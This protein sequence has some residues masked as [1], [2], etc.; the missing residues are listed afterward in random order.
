MPKQSGFRRLAADRASALPP[1][2]SL[3]HSSI[4]IGPAPAC[5]RR[6][7]DTH[8]CAGPSRTSR[9]R[10]IPTCRRRTIPAVGAR[11]R[12]IIRPTTLAKPESGQAPSSPG[13]PIRGFVDWACRNVRAWT[14]PALP[15][16]RAG[17]DAEADPSRPVPRLDRRAAAAADEHFR[18]RAASYV[19]A[20]EAA[21]ERGR[22]RRYRLP[23]HQTGPPMPS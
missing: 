19:A 18:R 12:S 1:A 7:G 8:A 20:G 3:D 17:A 4:F 14:V 22:S 11:T 23:R 9:W 21:L 2:S 16:G 13:S 15:A 10:S 6:R 5:P